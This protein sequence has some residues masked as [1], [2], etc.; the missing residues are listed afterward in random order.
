MNDQDGTVVSEDGTCDI[1]RAGIVWTDNRNGNEDIYFAAG[2]SAPILSVKSVSGGFGVSAV[3][4]NSGNAE[5]T[6]TP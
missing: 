6:D 5:A 1:S 2:E 4:E 3:I